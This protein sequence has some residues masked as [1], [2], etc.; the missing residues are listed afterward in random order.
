MNYL[1]KRF[2]LDEEIGLKMLVSIYIFFDFLG[3][4]LDLNT[5]E[6]SMCDEGRFRSAI[7]IHTHNHLR[8]MRILACLSIVGFRDITLKLV[9]FLDK[10]TQRGTIGERYRYEFEKSWEIYGDERDGTPKA[11]AKAMCFLEE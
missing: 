1:E 3:I 5:F 10:N 9:A 7:V 2:F 8:L 6:L 11:K 4:R